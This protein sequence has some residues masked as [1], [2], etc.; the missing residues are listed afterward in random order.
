MRFS[1]NCAIGRDGRAGRGMVMVAL[2]LALTLAAVA[3]SAPELE[4]VRQP[5]LKAL[6]AI[7][8]ERMERLQRLQSDYLRA[9][10]DLRKKLTAEGNLTGV[11]AV[12]AE[13]ARAAE[14]Q[15]PTPVQEREMPA[16][17]AQLR[18]QF[19]ADRE[20]ILAELKL[21]DDALRAGYLRDLEALQRRLTQEDKIEAAL[22][23]KAERDRMTAP[24][25]VTVAPPPAPPTEEEE[26]QPDRR[27]RGEGGGDQIIVLASGVKVSE[28][29]D[30]ET[31]VSVDRGKTFTP[32]VVASMP[33]DHSIL[34]GTQYLKPLLLPPMRDFHFIR[35]KRTFDL[36]AGF[37][38]AR[39]EIELYANDA[40]EVYL[41]A[42]KFGAQPVKA[43]ESNY[44]APASR[45][46]IS[47]HGGWGEE[48]G[49]F[50]VGQNE[51]EIAVYDF[52]P[53]T[54]VNFRA[55][56]TYGAP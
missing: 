49:H 47:S 16:A 24:A 44:R 56:V 21:R 45:F 8:T 17:L 19:V 43:V 31:V 10:E 9:L 39:L 5:F 14:W 12:R 20:R 18:R 35:F 37:R 32:A 27:R 26:H 15:D 50:R 54:G 13:L 28:G 48:T 1:N 23:V 30:L 36:P 51:L 46:S 3:Q 29:R 55:T 53:P 4:A 33:R 6:D 25:P 22:A 7:A 34:E 52:R 2:W 40:A 11:L 42:H 38:Y 41:N